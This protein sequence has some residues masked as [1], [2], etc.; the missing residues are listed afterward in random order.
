[1]RIPLLAL[2][3]LLPIS[4]GADTKP[5]S[6]PPESV[7]SPWAEIEKLG[8]KEWRIKKL[9]YLGE[10]ADGGSKGFWCII[11]DTRNFQIIATNPAYWTAE[12]KKLNRQVYY[13]VYKSRFYRLDPQTEEESNLISILEKSELAEQERKLANNL[14]LRIK[15]RKPLR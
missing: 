12:D 10:A 7:K 5:P 8:F 2:I 3:G 6:L 11:D 15:S 1:M 14:I 9:T 13:I 4:I